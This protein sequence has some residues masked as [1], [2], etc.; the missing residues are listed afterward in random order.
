MA[1][2]SVSGTW[3]ASVAKYPSL[4]AAS[5][6]MGISPRTLKRRMESER[7]KLPRVDVRGALG[8]ASVHH[9]LRRPWYAVENRVLYDDGRTLELE[10]LPQTV[11]HW[12]CSQSP[13][14]H[15]DALPFLAMVKAEWCPDLVVCHG[16]EAD[17]T[18]LKKAFMSADGPGPVEELTQVKTFIAQ[19]ARI[20][21]K[22]LLL[23]S[24]HIHSRIKFAQ[25]QGNI[26]GIMLRDWK[27]IIEAPDDWAWR[28]FIIARD[29]LWEHGNDVSKGSRGTIVEET[30]KRFGR[31]LSITRGHQ[32]SEHGLH[33][34]PV[35]RTPTRQ[36]WLAYVGTLMDPFRVGYTRAP[37]VT[38]CAITYRGNHIPV[39]MPKDRHGRWV[40]H[41]EGW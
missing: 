12:S 34:K 22:M 19:A 17:L 6:G 9:S 40:G 23:T 36:V 28:D 13:L 33:V 5:R 1:I 16:D 37:C 18:F 3:A 27:D 8:S 21:P 38:G 41:L 25:A 11:L 35:W 24:N 2:H 32:H 15:P 29:H 30:I 4:S 31:P 39:P 14:N 7:R 20:F 10:H 26:P